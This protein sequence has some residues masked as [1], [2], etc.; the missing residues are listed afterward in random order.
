MYGECV[1]H[2]AGKAEPGEVSE[3]RRGKRVTGGLL[4][5]WDTLAQLPLPCS[6]ISQPSEVRPEWH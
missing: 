4:F 2:A 1:F 6:E 3:Q 5:M